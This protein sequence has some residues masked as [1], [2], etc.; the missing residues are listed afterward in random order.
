MLGI[1]ESVHHRCDHHDKWID[2][3]IDVFDWNDDVVQSQITKCVI[4]T[5]CVINSHR[6]DHLHSNNEIDWEVVELFISI[7]LCCIIECI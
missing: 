4:T 7:D 2:H 5:C 1:I 3:H 6:V